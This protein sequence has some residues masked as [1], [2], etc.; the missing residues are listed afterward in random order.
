MTFRP[1]AESAPGSQGDDA[2]QITAIKFGCEATTLS[3][4]PRTITTYQLCRST[5]K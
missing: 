5:E 4:Q 1:E 2:A 3:V